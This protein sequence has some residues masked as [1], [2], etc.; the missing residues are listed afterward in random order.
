MAQ[1]FLFLKTGFHFFGERL[2][3]AGKGEGLVLDAIDGAVELGVAHADDEQFTGAD[4][5]LHDARGEAGEH[6][7]I[8][9]NL[10]DGVVVLEFEKDLWAQAA[11]GELAQ[12]GFPR[13]RSRFAQQPMAVEQR[14]DGIWPGL[15]QCLVRSDDHEGFLGEGGDFHGE[16][17]DVPFHEPDVKQA[18]FHMAHDIRRIP[19]LTFDFDLMVPHLEIV[20]DL[21]QHEIGQ[22][23]GRADADLA[24][25]FV[26]RHQREYILE[27]VIQRGQPFFKQPPLVIEPDAPAHAIE[28]R[29]PQFSFEIPER[30]GDRR[31]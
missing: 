6:T 25:Q 14:F 10:L 23:S 12:K 2:P 16:V 24:R 17:V 18:V 9:E 19:R 3:E 1:A 27:L 21:R 30:A 13:S 11:R 8:V 20:Q 4:F 5:P 29:N 26:T 22:R 15:G 31:L 28:Q 7:R